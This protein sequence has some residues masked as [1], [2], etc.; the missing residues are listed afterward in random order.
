M[1]AVSKAAHVEHPIDAV[2]IEGGRVDEERWHEVDRVRAVQLACEQTRPGLRDATA[3]LAECATFAGKGG[4]ENPLVVFVLVGVVG[5]GRDPVS[6]V[7]RIR[8]RRARQRARNTNELEICAQNDRL[9]V[10]N[11]M[12]SDRNSWKPVLEDSAA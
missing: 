7:S 4:Y 12:S 5:V 9:S 6:E 1:R 10:T 8:R 3:G 2:L 11:L